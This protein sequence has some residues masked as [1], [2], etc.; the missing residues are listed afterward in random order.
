VKGQR[1]LALATSI[2][3]FWGAAAAVVDRGSGAPRL[4]HASKSATTSAVSLFLGGIL[5]SSSA[6]W[7]ALMRRL[8]SG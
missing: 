3:G 1:F 6:H 7:I 8:F 5:R 4:I 2:R